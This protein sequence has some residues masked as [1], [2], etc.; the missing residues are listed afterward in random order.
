M[1][2]ICLDVAKFCECGK[3]CKRYF[4]KGKPARYA[5][6]CADCL[7]PYKR[8]NGHE[9]IQR[10]GRHDYKL[11]RLGPQHWVLEHILIAS[12][13]I[14]PLKK[15]E[16][17]HHRNGNTLDNRVENLQ[18]VSR[19]EHMSIHRSLGPLW[20]VQ[21]DKCIQCGTQERP[22]WAR[23]LCTICYKRWWRAH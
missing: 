9:R 14:R 12:T 23:G 3:P 8:H 10:Y 2:V 5:K 18:I 13:K 4:C 1:S 15:G 22:H 20:A 17:I 19:S 7:G 11:I 6:K 16:H 21:H